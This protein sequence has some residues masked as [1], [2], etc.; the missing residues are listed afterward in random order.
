MPSPSATPARRL[1]MPPP[2]RSCP[3]SAPGRPTSSRRRRAGGSTP[4]RT[5]S[6]PTIAA[7]RGRSATARGATFPYAPGRERVAAG[8]RLGRPARAGG[9]GRVRGDA[10]PPRSSRGAHRHGEQPDRR[11]GVPAPPRPRLRRG[12]PDA[13]SLGAALAP[14]A[15]DGGGHGRHPA[16]R[17]SSRRASSSRAWTVL[18]RPSVKQRHPIQ[19]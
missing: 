3:C 5:S 12:L 16:D 1:P 11:R 14:R 15:R 8:P 17:V 13:T 7:R 18:P 10:G 9:D 6:S 4:S 2:R 19:P